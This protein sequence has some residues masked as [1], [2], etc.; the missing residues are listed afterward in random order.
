MS[1]RAKVRHSHLALPHHTLENSVAIKQKNE[2]RATVLSADSDHDEEAHHRHKRHDLLLL[3]H[4]S[5]FAST[6]SNAKEDRVRKTH[7]IEEGHTSNTGDADGTG[8]NQGGKLAEIE[9][10]EKTTVGSEQAGGLQ[11]LPDSRDNVPGERV[12]E[13]ERMRKTSATTPSNN[14]KRKHRSASPSPPRPVTLKVGVDEE[15]FK[16]HLLD[17]TTSEGEEPS[18]SEGVHKNSGAHRARPVETDMTNNKKS[19]SQ[20]SPSSSPELTQRKVINVQVLQHGDVTSVG[21]KSMQ[22]VVAKRQLVQKTQLVQQDGQQPVKISLHV[23]H[24][25]NEKQGYELANWVA[26]SE[27]VTNVPIVRKSVIL[28]R[29]EALFDSVIAH[30][31]DFWQRETPISQAGLG[32]N[33]LYV[34]MNPEKFLPKPLSPRVETHEDAPP[35]PP[36]LR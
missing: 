14:P 5:H 13:K 6:V 33:N 19:E 31:P 30:D 23:K 15:D 34:N 29:P 11:D 2:D 16:R 3:K 18:N 7:V 17:G 26:S 21:T 28:Q 35:L 20:H 24:P 1:L 22:K 36:I 32:G 9:S 25:R 8:T 4:P 12:V 10:V 27:K